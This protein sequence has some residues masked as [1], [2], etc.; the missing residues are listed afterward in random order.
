MMG[1]TMDVREIL[2]LPMESND[3]D[4]K[5]LGE[6]IMLLGAELFEDQEDFS[7]KRPFGNS[8]WILDA[9][10]PLIV[11]GIIDGQLDQYGYLEKVDSDAG[12]KIFQ[13]IFVFL[14]KLDY[15]TIP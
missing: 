10:T 5:T 3:A 7:G 14:K 13:E 15:T 11:A 2:M 8:G 4:A 9:Y 6:F 1:K 12:D